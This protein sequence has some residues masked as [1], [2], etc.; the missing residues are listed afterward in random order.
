MKNVKARAV[1]ILIMYFLFN[2]LAS[3]QPLPGGG[4]GCTNCFPRTINTNRNSVKFMGQTFSLIDTNAAVSTDTNLYNACA[5]FSNDTGTNAILQVASYGTNAIIIKASHF[6]YSAEPL[7]D[8]ALI[9]CDK[10][11]S[12]TW[13]SMSFNNASNNQDGWLVQGTVANWQVSD[14]MFLMVSNMAHDCDSFFRAIPYAGPQIAL[15]G[16]SPYAT[17]QSNITLYATITDLSG[18][19]NEQFDINVNG[20]P[21]RY[22]LAGSNAVII[23]THYNPNGAENIYVTATSTGRLYNTAFVPPDQQRIFFSGT[24]SMPLDFENDTYLA[25]ASDYC[26]TN[27]G[28]RACT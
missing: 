20:L 28:T 9:I 24:S 6:D 25:F 21:A 4:G 2:Q 19:T 23:D 13:K 10:A 1:G 18:I 8:F 27:V 26:P 3:S 16:Q 22:S 7:R 11:E 15:T 14:P 5:L 17:V 12:P